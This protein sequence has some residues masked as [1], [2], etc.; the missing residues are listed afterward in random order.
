MEYFSDKEVI[1]VLSDFLSGE[2]IIK[3]NLSEILKLI[4][5]KFYSQLEFSQGFE[6]IIGKLLIKEKERI[7]IDRGM[8]IDEKKIKI[9]INHDII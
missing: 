7:E 2:I 6:K 5:N 1:S 9:Q 3:M 8:K 4:P